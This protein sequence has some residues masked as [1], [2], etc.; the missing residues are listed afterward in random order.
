MR[1]NHCVKFFGMVCYGVF[2]RQQ[3]TDKSEL[4]GVSAKD[5]VTKRKVSGKD[6]KMVAKRQLKDE[7][8]NLR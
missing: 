6:L 4:G 7:L 8:Q 2:L 3:L 5:N 1:I